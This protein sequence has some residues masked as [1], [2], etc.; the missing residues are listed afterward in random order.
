VNAESDSPRVLISYSHDSPEHE[1]RV[2]RLA[3]RLRDDGVDAMLDQY[4]AFPPQG[5]IRWMSQQIAEARFVLAVCTPTYRRR[6]AGEEEPGRGLGATYEGGII[7][8]AIY[9]AGGWNEKFIPVVFEEEDRES[10]PV[11]LKRYQNYLLLAGYEDLYRLLT[12]QPKARKPELG[13]LRAMPARQSRSDFRNFIWNMPPRNPCF[14]GRESYLEAAHQALTAANAVALGGIGGIGK[15]QTAMEY[16]Y[17][18]RADYRFALWCSAAANASLLSSFAALANPLDLPEKNEKELSAVA[19][20]VTHWLAAN[21]GWLLVLDNID[22]V[23]DLKEV[24]RLAGATPAGS[25]LITTRL[26]STGQLGKLVEIHKMDQDEGG[27][28]LLRRAAIAE[29]NDSDRTC[30]RRISEEVDGLPLALDQAGAFIEETPSTPAEYLEFCRTEG[31]RLRRLRG[32]LAADHASV[33]VTFSLAFSRLAEKNAAAAELVRACAFLAPDA[34]PEEIFTNGG[35]KL[36][37]LPSE[38]AGKPLEFAEALRDAGRFALVRRNA[39][40]KCLNI[41]RQVQEVLKDGMDAETRHLWAGRVVEAL[42]AVFPDPEFRNWPQCERLLPHARVAARHIAESG[43]ETWEAARLLNDTAYYLED[44]AEYT[45]AEP[46]YRRALEI[47]EKTLGPNH[48]D[49]ATS[50]NNLAVLFRSQRRYE[51]AEPLYRRALAIDEKALGPDHP[52]TATDLNNLGELFRRQGRHEE[53]EPLHRRALAIVEK[54]QGADHPNTATSLNNLAGLYDNQGRYAEAEPLYRRALSIREKALGPNHP[55]TATSLNNLASLYYSQGRYEEAE[56][57]YR[58]ALA[59]D[60]KALGT[61]HPNT[62]TVFN[63]F[64]KLLRKMGRGAEAA[65]LQARARAAAQ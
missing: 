3:D 39:V 33:T 13:R 46:L 47:R 44:R 29:A 65:E 10:I 53:A 36:G 45:E 38:L 48:S 61:D 15:T 63:N 54:A 14:T 41:H 28:F 2:L 57:L 6:L 55:N 30:A 58:R 24:R 5:W 18:H 31:S 35:A 20:G 32:D 37:D 56:P 27:S 7:Q 25:L 1:A 16:A 8:Q 17:R 42:A 43:L 59:I 34:I 19:A 4:E 50:L 52:D 22:T 26:Q 60:E 12:D 62:A 49:T 9:G 11:E 51:E 64:V 21:S 23:E 40:T